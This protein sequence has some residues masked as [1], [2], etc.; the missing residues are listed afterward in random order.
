SKR[1]WSSDVC[2]SDL[3]KSIKQI[4][5]YYT[6]EEFDLLLQVIEYAARSIGSDDTKAELLITTTAL[7]IGKASTLS[8]GLL[9]AQN[10]AVKEN[11]DRKSVVKGRQIES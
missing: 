11:K 3:V 1:D 6:S 9:D 7:R 2:S 4:F 5:K 8:K 10:E